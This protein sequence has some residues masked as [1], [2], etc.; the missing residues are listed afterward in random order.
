MVVGSVKIHRQ[1]IFPIGIKV[2]DLYQLSNRKDVSVSLAASRGGYAP[3]SWIRH[4]YR[5]NPHRLK[6]MATNLVQG[7]DW[8]CSS[9]NAATASKAA[10]MLYLFFL[11]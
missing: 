10:M 7:M 5:K 11:I 2:F 9:A 4:L 8:C 3:L 1:T 6:K